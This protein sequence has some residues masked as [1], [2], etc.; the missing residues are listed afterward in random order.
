M[1][2]SL[3]AADLL[4][5][6]ILSKTLQ[7]KLEQPACVWFPGAHAVFLL[8]HLLKQF[9]GPGI[10]LE[11]I[12]TQL[13]TVLGRAKTFYPQIWVYL[14]YVSVLNINFGC[15]TEQITALRHLEASFWRENAY[16]NTSKEMENVLVSFHL[17]SVP[18]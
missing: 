14:I 18:T 17:K 10:E 4:Y 15:F 2:L 5:F 16:N 11:H 13:A 12:R 9:L 8:L 7:L 3:E 6:W 1:Q